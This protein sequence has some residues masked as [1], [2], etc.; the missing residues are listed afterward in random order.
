MAIEILSAKHISP[1]LI[2][3][4][5]K[6]T[7]VPSTD[8]AKRQWTCPLCPHSATSQLGDLGQICLLPVSFCAF[9]CELVTEDAIPQL[10]L[11]P[12]H[13]L[14]Q[15][16]PRSC[17][18]GVD[19]GGSHL[20]VPGPVLDRWTG[21]NGSICDNETQADWKTDNV[22]TRLYG[23]M[24]PRSQDVGTTQVSMD[25]QVDKYNASHPHNGILLSL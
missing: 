25:G 11:S 1:V 4:V 12:R 19:H 2:P 8:T 23:N 3:S 16:Y 15:G 17:G 5:L 18:K 6:F 22:H 14:P 20:L 24:A 21:G 10:D 13:Q 9:I 7:H